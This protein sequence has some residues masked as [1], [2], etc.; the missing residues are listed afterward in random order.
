MEGEKFRQAQSALQFI[1]E[2]LNPE[3]RFNVITFSTGLDSFATRLQPASAAGEASGWV[4]RLSAGGSTDINRALL[5]AVSFTD[6]ERPTYLIF[7]TDG[8]PTEGVTDSQQILDNVAVNAPSNVRLF[9]FGVGYDVDTFLLDSLSQAHHGTSTYVVPGE[10]LDE[11][12][13]AF[14]EKIST[15]VLTDL[16]LDFGDIAAYDIYPS[17]L[18]DLFVGSQI[19]LVGRYRAGG[20]TEVTLQGEVDGRTET[21]RFPEQAFTRDSREGGAFLTALPRL[22]ATRK[23]GSLLN[24]VRLQGPDEETIDQ[25][26]RLSIRYGIVTPYTSY[27]VTEPMPLGAA[28]QD[29]IVDEEMFAQE[30]MPAAPTFGEGAVGRAAAEGDLAGAEAPAPFVE[31]GLEEIVRVVGSRTFVNAEGVWIDTAFDPE[32]MA[33]TPVAFLSPD[34]FALLQARPELAA[35]FALGERVIAF[36]DGLAYEVVP[37]DATVEPLDVPPTPELISETEVPGKT[38]VA[39]PVPVD[40]TTPAPGSMP[41]CLGGLLPLA[42]VPLGLFQFRRRLKK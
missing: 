15:P 5:E 23:I 25:I 16:S 26:V 20:V 10:R 24:Q 36:A 17:P 11:R 22:W 9:S 31:K 32:G 18:P 30:S 1:L 42:V 40:G 35:A 41:G 12:I 13:S 7:L 39:T 21:F 33:T 14:Y 2:N 38:S 3:D 27:L 6:R 34:Y 4:D 19:V 28:A 37:A 8:L 29:R